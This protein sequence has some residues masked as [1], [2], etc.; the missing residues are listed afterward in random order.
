MPDGQG[1]VRGISVPRVPWHEEK[2]EGRR[3]PA[4]MRRKAVRGGK[5][6]EINVP[7]RETR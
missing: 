4:V 2:A 6:V 7:V 3:K 5:R 1:R